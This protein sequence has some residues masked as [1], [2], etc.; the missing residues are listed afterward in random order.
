MR[1]RRSDWRYLNLWISV[2]KLRF[3]HF[4][5]GLWLTNIVNKTCGGHVGG[6]GVCEGGSYATT[7]WGYSKTG[8]SMPN[9]PY[10]SD[11]KTAELRHLLKE[12]YTYRQI[13]AVLNVSKN[14]LIGR[15]HRIKADY[16]AGRKWKVEHNGRHHALK[17]R[18]SKTARRVKPSK[19]IDVFLALLRKQQYV[20]ADMLGEPPS[21]RVSFVEL[22]AG[23]CRYVH[24]DPKKN[25]HHFCG[26][27]QQNLGPYCSFHASVCYVKP[28]DKNGKHVAKTS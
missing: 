4:C 25:N 18:R 12:G 15:V 1:D 7:F 2:N 17:K 10:W 11:E 14:A 24:G 27:P 13:A 8:G 23:Q 3:V 26:H 5:A 6:V 28:R 22:E 19:D 21:L 20:S 9:A 16:P